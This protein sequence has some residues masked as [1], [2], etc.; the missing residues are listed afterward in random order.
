MPYVWVMKIL[1]DIAGNRCEL[2]NPCFCELTHPKHAI[3]I[4]GSVYSFKS[5]NQL[6][7]DIIL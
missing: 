6:K 7:N 1:D 5:L 2:K 3:F 4:Y